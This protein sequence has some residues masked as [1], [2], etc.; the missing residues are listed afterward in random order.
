[1]ACGSDDESSTTPTAAETVQSSPSTATSS[2]AAVPPAA[3]STPV[4]GKITVF[5][6]ASLTD[7]FKAIGTAFS[8]ANPKASVTFNFAG[9]SALATQINEGA[10]ADVFASADDANY[11]LVAAKGTIDPQAIFATNVPVI[12]APSSGS[13]VSSFEDLA[14]RGVKLVLAAPS[15]PIGNYARQIFTNAS[16]EGGAGADFSTKVLANLK[17]NETDVKSVLAKI[18][19]GE[20]DAGVVYKTDAAIAGGQVRTIAIPEK[21]NIVAQYPIGATKGSGNV[22]A[23]RAFVAFVLSDAGQTILARHGF[24]K[25]P[26]AP[27]ATFNSVSIDGMVEKPLT[28]TTAQ[29]AALPQKT[30]RATDSNSTEKEYTGAAIAAILAQAGI[31][32]GATQVT[33]RGADGYAQTLALADLDKDTGAI[34]VVNGGG[35]SLRNIIPSQPPRTWIPALVKVE[36]K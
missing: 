9:S 18:Q 27:V 25:R 20:G 24:G 21:Y 3:T 32:A 10:P 13:P 31:R 35:A 14:K 23:A 26:A 12:V 4:E 22:A 17:S 36:V 1:M 19:V 28:L 7:A 8:A 30:V 29:V 16:T 34:I 5:A 11:R 2:Q 15:V 33:F 6:A